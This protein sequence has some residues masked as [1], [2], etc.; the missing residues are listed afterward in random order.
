MSQ[1]QFLIIR[2][3]ACEQ[4]QPTLF[5]TKCDGHG[6]TRTEVDLE[7]AVEELLTRRYGRQI[8]ELDADFTAFFERLHKVIK[9]VE[10]LSNTSPVDSAR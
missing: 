2:Q 10:A 7:S 9:T 4:C 6:H 5:C 1:V 3:E 8:A